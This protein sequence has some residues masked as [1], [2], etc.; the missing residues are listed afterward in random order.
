[1]KKNLLNAMVLSA[2]AALVVGCGTSANN[3]A[4]KQRTASAQY[5]DDQKAVKAEVLADAFKKNA[6]TSY[7]V[8]VGDTVWDLANLFLNKPWLWSVVWYENPKLGNS[9]LIYA[10][11]VLTIVEVKG[12]KR[13]TISEQSR[14][15]R[16][17]N[18]RTS[19]GLPTYKISPHVRSTPL[20]DGPISFARNS[21]Q[22][23]QMRNRI[24][25]FDQV[26]K[27][28]K[29]FGDQNEYLA[30]NSAKEIFAQGNYYHDLPP[31]YS[32]AIEQ[33]SRIKNMYDVLRPALEINKDKKTKTASAQ[34][35]EYVGTIEAVAY[36]KKHNLTIFENR[37]STGLMKEGDVFMPVDL[38]K[39]VIPRWLAD[40]REKGQLSQEEFNE[41]KAELPNYFPR[42]PAY[43]G[44][45]HILGSMNKDRLA[46]REFDSLIVSFGK[47]TGAKVGD[48][49][50]I[51]RPREARKLGKN[52]AAQLPDLELGYLMITE[53]YNDA[54]VGFVLE[55]KQDIRLTDLLVSP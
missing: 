41:Y 34:E 27:L 15:Y 13:I 39:G 26:S 9:G 51:V 46:V 42:L 36:D 8:R 50:K 55:G 17:L 24:V 31:A 53:V 49:W 35:M 30:L 16:K 12:Q 21:V 37:E 18:V 2:V 19:S 1:M 52:N 45:G 40:L 28:P 38:S 48:I 25:D 54:S 7:T 6:P 33:K 22:A 4:D 47:N 43:K 11:D 23:L 5:A 10:G 14:Q 44:E 29:I 20:A 3:V 32:Q